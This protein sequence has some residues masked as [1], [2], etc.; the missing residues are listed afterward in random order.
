MNIVFA[1]SEVEELVKTGGLA[2]VGKALPLALQKMGHDVTI[3]MPCYQELSATQKLQTVG[4]EQTLFAEGQVY[5]YTIRQLTW[6]GINVYL[7]DY[8]DY[9][10][11]DGLYSSAY[12]AFEDNGE[13][14]SFFS[15]AVLQVLQAVE[16]HPDIIH[17]H[18]WHAAMLP[19]LL[20]H[21]RSGY[22]SQTRTVFTIHNAA[23]QGV[24][25]LDSIPFLRHHPAILS[26]VHGGYINMLQSGITF[27]DKITTVSPNYALEL[28]TDLGSHGLHERLVTRQQDLIGILNGCDYSQ[29]NPATDTQ[30]TVN[31]DTDTLHKKT[32]CKAHLQTSNGLTEDSKT[33]VIGMVC[34]LTEQ[35]GFGYLVPILDALMQHNL[36]MVIVGTGDPKVCMDLGE[37]AQQHPRQFAFINGFSN[38]HAHQVEAGADFFLMPSQFEPCGLNQMYSLAYGTVPI[39]RGVGGLKDTVID[40]QHQD[41]ATGFV[42][43]DPTPEALLNCIRRALLFYHEHPQQFKAM[44]LRGMHTRFTWKD[45]ATHY[46]ALYSALIAQESFNQDNV[47]SA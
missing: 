22:F 43:D 18:D 8:P 40:Y 28:L 9:F 31:Y 34:R 44:Q 11:R 13:R 38:S 21:E 15:G 5:H 20:R 29:W 10:D 24:H 7:V 39:V 41:R 3:V 25:R 35:K 6:R 46:G 45:A 4:T 32:D 16:L 1:I 47:T 30:L 23:F 33:P 42:F 12:N 36:Q 2:D 17:C 26:Q 14:F 37:Y 27:A 19:F